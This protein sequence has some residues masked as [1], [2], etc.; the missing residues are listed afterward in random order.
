MLVRAA[1]AICVMASAIAAPADLRSTPHN[2]GLQADDAA[3][4]CA[5]CHIPAMS[6]N[7]AKAPRWQR[8]M[9]TA[10]LF[11]TYEDRRR[12]SAVGRVPRLPRRGAGAR[13]RARPSGGRSLPRAARGRSAARGRLQARLA[14]HRGWP[15]RV[16]G[17]AGRTRCQAR[18][19]R[20]A[21]VFEPG[22]AS[23]GCG[24]AHRMRHVPRPA[25]H[26]AGLSSAHYAAQ[27][28]LP[29]LPRQMKE[30]AR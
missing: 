10:Q 19:N 26:R 18:E 1:L 12:G 23:R 5:F 3:A 22:A 25:Q 21:A 17:F 6:E 7:G 27:R 28:A 14:R 24:A 15:P 8:A 9:S 4:L 16:V 29:G 20:S 30:P 2:L 13:R 11:S